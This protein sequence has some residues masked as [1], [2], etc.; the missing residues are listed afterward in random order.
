MQPSTPLPLLPLLPSLLLL[1][2]PLLIP[3]ILLLPHRAAVHIV[4]LS[5]SPSSLLFVANQYERYVAVVPYPPR[6]SPT[7]LHLMRRQLFVFR[8]VCYERE[9]SSERMYYR[10]SM[11]P[12][13]ISRSLSSSSYEISFVFAVP[14]RRD[15]SVCD[16]SSG[17]FSDFPN[18]TYFIRYLSLSL[19]LDQIFS[20]RSRWDVIL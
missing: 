1:L 10:R 20:A 19:F 17:R 6:R 12:Y 5:L 14:M 8:G 7:C 4:C 15:W 13:Y 18:E 11:L 16:R 9:T 3:L 2:L